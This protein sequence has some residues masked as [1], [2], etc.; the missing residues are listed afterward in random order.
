MILADIYTVYT[1]L[2]YIIEYVA[3]KN[4]KSLMSNICRFEQT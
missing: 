1:Q 3:R 4:R 2:L